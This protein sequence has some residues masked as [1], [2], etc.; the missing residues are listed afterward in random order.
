V[1]AG[2]KVGLDEELDVRHI[3]GAAERLET[4]GRRVCGRLMGWKKGEEQTAIELAKLGEFVS[5][6]GEVR[7]GA[8]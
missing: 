3:V 5:I 2:L 6:W 4:E 1:D 8:E 7:E